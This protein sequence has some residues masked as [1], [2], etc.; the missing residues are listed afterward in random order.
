MSNVNE[1]VAQ[2]EDV[3]ATPENGSDAL[4]AMDDAT[5]AKMSKNDDAIA[6]IVSL[7]VATLDPKDMLKKYAKLGKAA[8]DHAIWQKNQFPAWADE[9]YKRLCER[10]G[11]QVKFQVAIK[12]VRIDD[13]IRV[14]AW[15]EAVRPMVPEVERISF[16]Q[17]VNKF[18][19]M[20]S[21][22]RTELSGEIK[23]GWVDFVKA[24]VAQQVS[25]APMSIKDLDAAIQAHAA[26]LEAERNAGKSPEQLAEAERRKAV[27]DATR[28][29]MK[30]RE[31]FTTSVDEALG[32]ILS[33][34]Q[35][36]DIV[37][38]VAKDR[39]VTL[40]AGNLGTIAKM[41]PAEAKLLAKSMWD[42]GNM[43]SMKVLRDQLDVMVKTF[44]N[45]AVQSKVG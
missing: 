29:E 13:Y 24:T 15:V 11:D 12:S 41:T 43:A 27:A 18:L 16:F 36:V 9:D 25:D 44:E 21:W 10:I 40:P 2:T 31:D 39:G 34:S 3:Q 23:K 20:L 7:A 4:P 5:A 1:T 19:P 8:L 32:G 22:S 6:R 28:A 14:H 30:A 38:K 17:V 26:H 45:A 37:N 42:A 35:L 33:P